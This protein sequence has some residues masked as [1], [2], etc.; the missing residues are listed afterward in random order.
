MPTSSFATIASDANAK[1]SPVSSSRGAHL[2]VRARRARAVAGWAVPTAVAD[3]P[4]CQRGPLDGC[5]GPRLARPRAHELPAHG[6]RRRVLSYGADDGPRPLR[7]RARGSPATG[8]AHDGGAGAERGR[9]LAARA[10]LR[11]GA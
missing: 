9:G 10:S 3:R 1:E 6:R 7:R 11:R 5:R 2:T 8:P 4:V